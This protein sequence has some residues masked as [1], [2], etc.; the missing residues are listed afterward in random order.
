MRII[1]CDAQWTLAAT[2]RTRGDLPFPKVLARLPVP[3]SF[4]N[5][6]LAPRAFVDTSL[7]HLSIGHHVGQ[8]H[9]CAA[10]RTGRARYD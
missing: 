4:R 2:R 3:D 10:L 7:A 6:V 9:A 8:D 5:F 1:C